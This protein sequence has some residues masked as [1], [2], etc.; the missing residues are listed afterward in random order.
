VTIR[1]RVG[2][3]DLEIVSSA[4]IVVAS[5]RLAPAGAGAL[6]RH[7][8]HRIALEQ[9]VLDSLTRTRK[10]P[11]KDNRPPSEAALAAAAAIAGSPREVVV[12]LDTYA[13]YARVAR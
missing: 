3:K 8:E 13:E 11:R 7:S 1:R 2:S 9:V 4:G 6:H 10:C 12:S 5:H